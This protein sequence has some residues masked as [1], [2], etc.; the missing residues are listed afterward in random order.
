[1]LTKAHQVNRTLIPAGLFAEIIKVDIDGY[2]QNATYFVNVPDI[3]F[4]YWS[5][6][7]NIKGWGECSE[8][9]ERDLN[10]LAAGADRAKQLKQ[11]YAGQL[12]IGQLDKLNPLKN[13]FNNQ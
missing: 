13:L 6:E 8:F 2:T 7:S 5:H 11:Y 9:T 10:I 4:Q 12:T 3:N 1:M